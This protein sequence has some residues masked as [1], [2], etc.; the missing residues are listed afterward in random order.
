MHKLF[1]IALASLLYLHAHCQQETGLPNNAFYVAK[2]I[3]A[4]EKGSQ[5]DSITELT[6]AKLLSYYK[7]REGFD[8]KIYED[9]P[10]KISN[11]IVDHLLRKYAKNYKQICTLCDK[12]K[13]GNQ[14]A[15]NLIL[16]EI[17]EKCSEN[18]FLINEIKKN[19]IDIERLQKDSV[20]IQQEINLSDSWNKVYQ[21]RLNQTQPDTTK[22]IQDELKR[23][24][25]LIKLVNT[26]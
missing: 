19:N 1:C 9:F 22:R 4:L 6:I 25:D 3:A 12:L 20:T 5:K 10:S 21:E 15:N 11:I 16:R 7:T 13:K 23:I 8:P 2:E 26:E 24:A 17:E 18:D 14:L